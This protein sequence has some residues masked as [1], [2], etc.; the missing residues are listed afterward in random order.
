MSASITASCEDRRARR[1]R[2]LFA[3]LYTAAAAHWQELL[4]GER[5]EFARTYL[6]RRGVSEEIARCFRLGYAPREWHDL[7]RS[8]CPPGITAPVL[9]AV[10]LLDMRSEAAKRRLFYDRF[11]GRVSFPIETARG[12]VLG[13]A[14]R[15]ID[16]E[17]PK[18]VDAPERGPLSKRHVLY[19]LPKAREA[20]RRTGSALVVQGYFDVLVLHQAGF[21]STVAC[22][23]RTVTAEQVELLKAS[24]CRELVLLLDGDAAGERETAAAARIVLQA[25]L[26]GAVARIPPPAEGDADPDRFVLR[27]GT[28]SLKE[29]MAAGRPL[30]E[31]LIDEASSRDGGTPVRRLPWSRGRLESLVRRLGPDAAGASRTANG[32]GR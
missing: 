29:V 16:D 6:A 20:I 28:A 2:A 22:C 24:G 4:W 3:R 23:A 32:G 10:G 26:D 21:R 11:R 19:G 31:C 12:R 9:H 15:A 8:L 17:A 14:G 18:Y 30:L 27:A 7:E 1:D 13:L 5:G 25:G